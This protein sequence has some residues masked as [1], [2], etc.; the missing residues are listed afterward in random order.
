MLSIDDITPYLL[1]QFASE[2]EQIKCISTI[3]HNFTSNRD[4]ID[5]YTKSE[6][7]VS[8]YALFY[9]LTNYPKLEASLKKVGL[10]LSELED[11]EFFDIGHGP[12]TYLYSLSILFPKSNIFG[13]EKSDLMVSQAKKLLN[14]L[15]PNHRVHFIK[16]LSLMPKKSQKRFG[17]F[18]HSANEMGVDEVLKLI[19]KLELDNILFLE[20]GTSQFFH[21][22]ALTLR[23]SLLKNS[24]SINYPCQSQMAC[25][26]SS[27]DDWCHQ[28]LFLSHHPSVERLCQKLGKNR[29]LLPQTIHYYSKEGRAKNVG[30]IVIQ[31][32][33]DNKASFRW[34]V[35]GADNKNFEIEV[36]K[37]GYNKKNLKR[38]DQMTLGDNV[39]FEI[40]K[41]IRDDL[42]RVNLLGDKIV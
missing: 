8:A 2:S 3:S 6:K 40:V 7:L 25:P 10:S 23:E 34:K 35:C 19:D 16:D 12:G 32:L 30:A 41:K 28:Y 9:F 21:Q 15:C 37:R 38:L 29:R 39:E 24:F 27:S 26:M 5:D 14:G 18:G 33:G 4:A 22:K 1:Y 20:P 42:F 13:I 11:C 36:L 31:R 17:V